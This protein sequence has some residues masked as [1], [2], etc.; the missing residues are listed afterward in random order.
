M[1]DPPSDMERTVLKLDA[2]G[3]AQAEEFD[4]IL[5]DE[6][7]VR[8]IQNQLLPRCLGGEQFLKLRDILCFD[9]A[10]E[11]EQD[12]TIPRSPSSQHASSL[13][14]KTADAANGISILAGQA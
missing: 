5:V 12:L 7:H 4:G 11:C 10:T 6:R 13:C 14:L 1:I 3:L 9:P 2:I 8:Q